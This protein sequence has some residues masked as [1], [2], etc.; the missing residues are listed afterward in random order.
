VT[1]LD[2]G[3]GSAVFVDVSGTK[4]D[5]LIDA[6]R[7]AAARH[8]LVPFLRRNGLGELPRLIITQWDVN[9]SGGLAGLTQQLRVGE[10]IESGWRNP[11]GRTQQ[12]MLELARREGI[13]LRR[14]S[15][16]DVM[17]VGKTAEIRVLHPSATTPFKTFDDNAMVLQIRIGQTRILLMSDAG[18][19][20]EKLLV[21]SNMD[22]NSDILVFGSHSKQ[23]MGSPEFLNRVAPR[24]VI[25]NRGEPWGGRGAPSGLL[26]QLAER[27]IQVFDTAL[28]GAVVARL[29]NNRVEIKSVLS[30][31]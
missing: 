13:P 18:E 9:H 22:L 23:Q 7:E 2:V 17:A 27:R 12:Q 14:V 16:G 4:N 20:V 6:G 15:A 29:K 11:A 30:P 25:L 1:F 21:G 28:C 8:T 24:T 31:P 3:S 26:Q 19:S 5:V 10:I